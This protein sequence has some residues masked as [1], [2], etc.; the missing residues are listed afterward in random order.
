M[1]DRRDV[2]FVTMAPTFGD[3]KYVGQANLTATRIDRWSAT[4]ERE[5][6]L[7]YLG[8]IAQV[9]EEK[10][11]STLLLPVGSS[12]LDPLVIA[13]AIAALTK[14]IKILFAVRPNATAPAVLARQFA[15]LDYL[16]GGRAIINIVSGGSPDELAADG[17]FLS[18]S[19]RYERAQEFIHVVKRL[20]LGETVNHE[21]KYYTLKDAQ[22]FPAPAQKPRPPIFFGGASDIAKQVAVSEADVYMLWG[23]T[24]ENIRQR[25]EEVRALADSQGKKLRYSVSFQVILG[26]TE[27]EAWERANEIVSRIDPKVLK[28]KEDANVIDESV[29][30]KRLVDLMENSRKDNFKIGPNLWAG[31]TQVLGGNSIALVG[32]PDQVADRIV[33]YI[34]LGF[35]LVLLRGFPHLETIARV[36]DEIIP[37]VRERLL[38]SVK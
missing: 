3:G 5:P 28:S 13:S 16:T 7:E 19:E 37:R 31:L 17:D 14:K 35:D 2:E 29:G 36:G 38:H 23:E 26:D 21:G 22:L 18:H 33:E 32:T 1:G 6:S 24:L 10:G 8:K 34:D 30:H 25:I 4:A 27:E 15:S 9:A 11:F 20:L 12:S